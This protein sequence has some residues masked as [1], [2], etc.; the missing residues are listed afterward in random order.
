MPY[1]IRCLQIKHNKK[2]FEHSIFL[3]KSSTQLYTVQIINNI[4]IEFFLNE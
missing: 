4:K 1:S 2:K 3:K